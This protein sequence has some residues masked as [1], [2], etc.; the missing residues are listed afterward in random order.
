MGI[1]GGDKPL[2]RISVEKWV[3][4]DKNTGTDKEI[5]RERES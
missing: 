2:W 1:G 4:T 3:R 5:E